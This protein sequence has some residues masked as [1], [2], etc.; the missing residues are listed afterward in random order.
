MTAD[1][2]H[3]E[4]DTGCKEGARLDHVDVYAKGKQGVF[5]LRESINWLSYRVKLMG[6]PEIQV[7]GTGAKFCNFYDCFAGLPACLCSSALTG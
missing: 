2:R 6:A 4:T 5:D 1:E 7:F 3:G